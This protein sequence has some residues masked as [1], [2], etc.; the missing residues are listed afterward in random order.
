MKSQYDHASA[1]PEIVRRWLDS[2]LWHADPEGPPEEAYATPNSPPNV[3][4]AL[5]MGHALNA[6]LRDTLVR[7]NRVRGKRTTW[8]YGT[9]HAGIAT[10]TRVEARVR[11]EGTSRE[12]MGRERFE[13]RVWQWCDE[14]GSTITSQFQRLGASAD[15][16]EPHFTLD[17]DYSRVVMMTFV[18]LYE[19]GCI[20]R[21]N[22]LVNWDPGSGSAI[23][24]FEVVNREVT[25]QLYTVAYPLVGG[26]EIE[27][28]TVRPETI[29][30]DTAIAVHPEDE[31]YTGLLG[32]RA[33]CPLVE[34]ELPIV[35]DAEIDP[36]MGTGA[37]KVSPAHDPVD[38][39]IA[40]RHDLEAIDVIGEDGLIAEVGGER[41]AGLPVAEARE[42]I[43]ET[44]RE[45]GA[46]RRSE[47]HTHSVPFSH[48]SGARIEPL[49][50][51]QWF[52]D[53][54]PIAQPAIDAVEE[55]RVTIRPEPW[56]RI[57]LEW[58]RD[59]T[60]WCISRQLWWGHQLPVWY[61]GEE[62]YVGV[63]EPEGEG[64]ERDPDVLDTWYSATPWPFGILGW[65]ERT[66]QMEAFYPTDV[67]LT[68]R[69][70]VLMWYP[71]LIMFGLEFAGDVPFRNVYVHSI[72]QAPDGRRMSKSLGTGI[73]PM[74]A[75]EEFGSDAL[76]FGLLTMSTA[77][78]VR[79]S[80][81]KIEQGK[82]FANKLWSTARFILAKA[83]KGAEPTPRPTCLADRWIL[84]RLAATRA[85][86]EERIGAYD[87]GAAAACLY[88]F[89]YDDLSANYLE[90]AKDRLGDGADEEL[91]AT[92]L[93]LLTET[94]VLAHPIM[95]FVTEEI[96][97]NLPGEEGFCAG[98]CLG[99]A[100]ALDAE[101]E[102]EMEPLM[103][104]IKA[105]RSWRRIAKVPE[106]A[107]VSAVAE[108]QLDEERKPLVA[109]AA[110]VEL[111]ADRESGDGWS[112]IAIPDGT[113]YL[114]SA[115]GGPDG[116][117]EAV[118]IR[119][120]RLEEQIRRRQAQLANDSFLA[121]APD[122]AIEAERQRLE[123]QQDE[124]ASL[125]G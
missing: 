66:P 75:I 26:G 81:T 110:K 34:R 25:D 115:N 113:L 108:P 102:R 125:P 100:G 60:P 14:Y 85:E 64:W 84:S 119:R 106:G 107:T 103:T 69:D 79:Y 116:G 35:A 112:P 8:V 4:G 67:M 16:S 44:L 68:A 104:I 105:I 62:I 80:T 114:R 36:E 96:W 91:S 77:Q 33:L 121:H 28:A 56:Q 21:G 10:Q 90:F 61:R 29:L 74:E 95:P 48:R 22:Y 117:E 9:D 30:G 101:A 18:H 11:E 76:R 120:E 118:A 93:H 2:G 54:K 19:K 31:R 94:V 70:I 7:Y 38:F 47:E 24:N 13:E 88:R 109:R 39:E 1:E 12:E 87:F 57:C 53:L 37:V 45:Q 78:D 15:Y 46:L 6:S 50:S 23:S 49:I 122:H 27:I 40:K 17:E 97:S 20:Y 123:R 86:F 99:P 111:L 55:G 82:R 42:R 32:R 3:T 51:L 72:I 73:D 124:L 89:V 65:P 41:F 52:L 71:H 58:M 92:L 59:P 5:H 83:R 43:L 63:E 98:A